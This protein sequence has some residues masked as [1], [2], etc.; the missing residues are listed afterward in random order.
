[1]S[2]FVFLL[3]VAVVWICTPSANAFVVEGP[4]NSTGDALADLKRAPR[5]ADTQGSLKENGVRGLGGGLEYAVDDSICELNFVDGTDCDAAKR[6]IDEALGRWADGHE[7]LTF[8]NVSA[9][10]SP[11]FP[12]AV[13]GRTDQGAEIDFYASTPAEFPVFRT[14]LTNGY[15]IFYS[16]PVS[17]LLLSNGHISSDVEAQIESADVRINKARCYYSDETLNRQDCVHFQTLI[18]HEIGHAL[19]IGHPEEREH[20]NLDTDDD[21]YN[22]MI[23]SCDA[24]FEGLRNAQHTTKTAVMV[25]VNVQAPNRW[26][27]GL[28]GDDIAARDALY[29]NCGADVASGLVKSDRDG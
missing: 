25:G 13:F 16:R 10:I 11:S 1:M 2:R 9:D 23:L 5:W 28:T 17:Q 21:P 3:V 14:P 18:F 24:P 27:F 19:G 7:Q 29:P 22:P 15:T 6:F 26:I 20:L 8:S 4:R 12:L